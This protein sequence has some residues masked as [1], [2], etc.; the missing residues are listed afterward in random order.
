MQRETTGDAATNKN[1]FGEIRD[2]VAGGASSN[3]RVRGFTVPLV[4]ERASGARI[5]DVEGNELID[6]NMGYGPHIL[7]YA[8]PRF[9]EAV[10]SQIRDGAMTGL[11]HR[12]D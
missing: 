5:W 2:V 7:G 4:V 12:L 6:L 8:D 1:T 3:M 10:G 9:A 11:P